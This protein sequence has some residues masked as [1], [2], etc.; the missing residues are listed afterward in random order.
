MTIRFRSL[1][2]KRSALNVERSL[3][4]RRRASALLAALVIGHC[5]L[6]T[7]VELRAAQFDLT[8]ATI[9]D[10]EAAMK[11]G[12]LTSE[13][14]TTAYLARISAYDKTGPK[15][16]TVITLNPDALPLA[17]ALDAER[18]A[19]KLR[20]ALH[21]IPVVLKDNFDTFDLPTTAGSKLLKDSL[22]PDDAFVV[23]KLRAAGAIILAKVNLSEFASGAG[24]PNGFSSMGGQT[25]NPHDLTRG[26]AGS[27]GGT[28]SAISAAFAQFGLGTDTGG[29]IRGPSAATGVVG[30]K[31]THGLLSRDGIVPLALTFDTG[32]PIARS[33]YDIALSLNVMT[34]V[35]SADPATKKSKGNIEKDYT[36]FLKK[37]S[38]KGARIGVARDFFKQDAETDRIMESAILKLRELGATVVDVSFPDYLLKIRPSLFQTVLHPEFK[39]QI[40][41]YLATLK[42]GYPRD[43][44]GLIALAGDPKTGYD[45]PWRLD[46][47]KTSEASAGTADPIYKAAATDGLALV[48]NTIL[49]LFAKDKLDALVY[50]TSPRPARPI[51]PEPNTAQSATNFANFT[52]F[53][54]LIVPAGMTQDGLPVTISFFGPAFSEGKLLSYGYDFEQATHA[55][56]L[57]TTTPKLPTDSL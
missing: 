53:P 18:K 3:H 41:T 8:T 7:S 43:L 12:S 47:M 20:G 36:A 6:V 11:S 40:A 57:P 37:G 26:P 44:A 27:S 29:S 34:G 2:V 49:G 55:I 21:G 15:L 39:E 50:P 33:V 56:T 10:L 17:R 38:L 42:P 54:D 22:P 19:G 31:P 5:S 35:D 13:K 28:G 4:F 51:K 14:L 9:A 16:N 23:K 30:L 32:G 45:N 1:S 48:S 46:N 52:G 25:L 24:G